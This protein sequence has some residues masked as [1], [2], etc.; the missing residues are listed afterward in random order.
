VNVT[1][2]G[3]SGF[4]GKRLIR[5]LLQDG[6]GVHVLGRSRK[7]DLPAEAGF[8]AWDAMRGPPPLESLERA[9]AVIHLAGEPAA[10]RWT[11]TVKRRIM[12]S[13]RLGTKHLVQALSHLP[14]KPKVLVSASASGYYGDRGEETLVESSDPGMGFLAEVCIEWEKQAL[15]A[16]KLGIRVVIMRIGVV[17]GNDGGALARM[18]PPFRMGVGGTLGSGQQWMS[19]IHVDDLI[20]LSLFA[21]ERNGVSGAVNG[22]A[23][24]AVRNT[25]FT[26]ELASAVHRP[27]ILPVPGF[28]LKLL[29]GE[30]SEILL[31]SQRIVPKVAEDAGFMFGHPELRG[32]LRNL[33]G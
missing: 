31:A 25:K 4:L 9:D 13:R 21:I 30:M 11:D 17:L 12:D 20:S 26:R 14:A 6:H 32:A 15:G 28:A 18:L 33:L 7:Q 10:Q 16:E 19:W 2:T 29:F 24:E 5:R 3:A 27:A 22:V 8:S 1:V 23:P